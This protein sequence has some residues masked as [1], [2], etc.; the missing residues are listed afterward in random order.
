M[1]VKGGLEGDELRARIVILDNR[2]FRPK[3]D[4]FVISGRLPRDLHGRVQLLRQIRCRRGKWVIPAP[5][6]G[7]V[8][9]DKPKTVAGG[10]R[11]LQE[12][13][14]IRPVRREVICAVKPFFFDDA[15]TTE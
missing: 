6:T 10:T 14:D 7:L 9:R 5:T 11:A 4:E 15:A 13:R 2:V 1:V 8:K 12:T 3:S